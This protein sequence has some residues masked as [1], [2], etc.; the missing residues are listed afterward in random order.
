M[1]S[2]RDS[3][4]LFAVLPRIRRG[5]AKGA[6]A[7][8]VDEK[9]VVAV[10]IEMANYLMSIE[11]EGSVLPG[12][13]FPSTAPLLEQAEYAYNRY[14]IVRENIENG[15]KISAVKELR[16]ITGMS[17]KEAKDVIEA[18]PSLPVF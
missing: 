5:M 3:A 14:P 9:A 10:A 1:I 17:L 15:K 8:A 13:T 16:R 6:F 11:D 7:H 18:S 2:D 12:T 4:A